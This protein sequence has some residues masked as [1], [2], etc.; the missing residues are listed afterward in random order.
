MEKPMT[1][2]WLAR[3][4]SLEM[5]REMYAQAEAG[6][7]R[8][9]T[10]RDELIS[11][12]PNHEVITY[13]TPQMGLAY[14]KFKPALTPAEKR[15]WGLVQDKQDKSALRPSRVKKRKE[16]EDAKGLRERMAATRTWGS[17]FERQEKLFGHRRWSI[18]D[19]DRISYPNFEKFDDGYVICFRHTP[20]YD[21]GAPVDALPI[22]EVTYLRMRADKLEA[23]QAR[24]EQAADV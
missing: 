4:R 20:S 9:L 8:A 1:S 2:Y 21:P 12:F 18:V 11:R 6:W 13:R 17:G 10:L 23:E 16:T 3:G 14:L 24:E 15:H 22:S 7:D 5:I 19:G